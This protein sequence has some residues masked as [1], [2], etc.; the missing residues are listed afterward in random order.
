MLDRLRDLFQ[1]PPEQETLPPTD[2]VQRFTDENSHT[3]TAAEEEADTLQTVILDAVDD[4]A[5]AL[6]SL[7]TYDHDN[8]RVDDVTTNIAVDRLRRIDTFAA[9]DDPEKLH[10][11]VTSLIG[12]LREVS[13]KEQ[14]VLD[15]VNGPVKDVFGQIDALEDRADEL[16]QFLTADYTVLQARQELEEL[17]ADWQQL[18]Q[19]R[20]D[21]KQE[22]TDVDTDTPRSRIKDLDEQLTALDDSPEQQRKDNLEQE[23]QGLQDE[24]QQLRQDIAS[25]ASNMERGLKKLLYAARN[26]DVSLSADHIKILETIRDGRIA[27]EFTTPASD[28]A[29]AVNAAG[30]VIDQVDLGERQ[31]RKFQ[32]GADTLQ[33]LDDMRRRMEGLQ[34]DIVAKQDTLDELSIDEQR[35][36]LKQDREQARRRLQDRIAE[37]EQLENRIQDKTEEI[38]AVRQEIEELLN[39]HVY[40]EITVQAA[41]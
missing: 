33:D 38:A 8:T 32:D 41:E 20:D 36:D 22:L 39:E 24:R 7:K 21:L 17:A 40:N 31:Q 19:A 34:D 27:Q 10:E 26:S 5:D 4:V 6:K 25:A 16:E 28:V 35:H 12:D 11:A 30:D 23:L 2:A 13:R 1:N 14:A 9:T 15:H 3:L 18:R 37:R 29:A